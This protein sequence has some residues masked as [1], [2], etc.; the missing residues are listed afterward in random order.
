[1]LNRDTRKCIFTNETFPLN[2]KKDENSTQFEL[3]YFIKKNLINSK[4]E[5]FLCSLGCSSFFNSSFCQTCLSG[6]NLIYEFPKSTKCLK[7]PSGCKSCFY[8][9]ILKP[10]TYEIASI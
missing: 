3:S 10:Y 6:D 5:L 9:E 2:M 8:G 1:M 4:L 7:C